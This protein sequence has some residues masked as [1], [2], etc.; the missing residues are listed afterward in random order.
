MIPIASTKDMS[1]E[2]W[3]EYRRLGV[4]GSD[5]SVVCGVNKYKSPIELWQEK[6]GQISGQEA[7]EAAH[8]GKMLEPIVRAEFTKRTGIEVIPVNQILRSREYPYMIANLDGVCRH[9][10]YGKCV[11]EAKTANAFKAGEWENDAVPYE[12]VLQVQHYMAVTGY[13]GA[14]VAV[15]IGGNKFEWRFVERDEEIISMLIRYEADFWRHVEDDVPPPPDGSDA[16]AKFLG[17]RF[18]NSVPQSRIELPDSAAVLIHQYNEACEGLEQLTEQKQKAANLLKA[19]LGE[20]ET[21]TVGDSVITWKSVSQERFDG[22]LFESEQ[23]DIHK[24]YMRKTTHR[25]FLVKEAQTVQ[26]AIA[27]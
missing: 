1:Y 17:Q 27:A 12:Y 20:N 24:Q 21:G 13:A 15:L 7:G 10:T 16:C 22:K 8:W 3:L 23:S 26:E 11:F 19:M 14:C 5:A 2:K 6:T 18:S 4:G 25:R 9:P